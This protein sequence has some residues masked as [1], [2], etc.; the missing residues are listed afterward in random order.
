MVLKDWKKEEG[1]NYVIFRN[2]KNSHLTYEIHEF[3]AELQKELMAKY[4]GFSAIDGK[5]V[6]SSPDMAKN[7]SEAL[8]FAKDYMKSH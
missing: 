4:Y 6:E 1:R 5:G 3:D 8:K 7:K 2:K